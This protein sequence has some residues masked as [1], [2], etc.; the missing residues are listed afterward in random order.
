MALF[1][2]TSGKAGRSPRFSDAAIQ[3]CLTLKNLFGL[4]LRQTTGLVESILQL[5]DRF[6]AARDAA[7]IPKA[8]FQ[9]RDLRATAKTALAEAVGIREAQALLGHTTERMTAH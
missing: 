4:P 1:T 6:D 2:A 9:F 7:G 5:R 8:E 3:F